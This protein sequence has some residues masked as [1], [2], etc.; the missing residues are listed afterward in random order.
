VSLTQKIW[1]LVTIPFVVA[2][3][4]YLVVTRPFRRELLLNEATRDAKDDVTV[5]QN[6]ITR[7]LIDEADKGADLRALVDSI[8]Q[9]ERVIGVA[10]FGENGEPIAESTGIKGSPRTRDLARRAL[11]ARA[12][13][14]EF[15]GDPTTLEHA[16]ILE[17]TGSVAVAVVI[18]DVS[19][20][21]RL[22]GAWTRALIIVGLSFAFIMLLVSGPL[23]RRIVGAPLNDAVTAVEK[24]AAGELEVA[25]D[26]KRRDELGRL[27]RSFNLMTGSLRHARA[28]VEEEATRRAALEARMR[29]LQTLAAAGEVAASLAHEIGSPLN[30]ILGRTRMMAARPTPRRTPSATSRSLRNKPSESRASCASCS[31]SADRPRA[32]SRTSTCAR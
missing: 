8:S 26:E 18:R 32:R 20:V 29:Q 16:F 11:A 3:A 14:R 23:V 12:E 24:V 30:V 4:S 31:T 21:D 2:I 27:A 9:A 25:L 15:H 28:E 7:G 13:I 17:K 19:Y 6:A 22:V 1:L 5:L 10:V